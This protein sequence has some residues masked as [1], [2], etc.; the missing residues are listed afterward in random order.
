M[1]LIYTYAG[2]LTF[3][4]YNDGIQFFLI[5]P[6]FL[7]LELVNLK[8]SGGRSGLMTQLDLCS[9]AKGMPVAW[10]NSRVPMGCSR[11]EL[12]IRQNI[13]ST[14]RLRAPDRAL[15]PSRET[16][17]RSVPTAALP[18]HI[19][20]SPIVKTGL[21]LLVLATAPHLSAQSPGTGDADH[22]KL[23]FQQSCAL[24]HA[25]VLG[26]GGQLVSGQ[27]PS[28]VGVV[29]RPAASLPNFNYS[30]ALL[31]SGLVWTAPELD[32]FLEAPGA[33]VPG[34]TMPVGVPKAQDRLD[35]IAFLSTVAAP[36]TSAG[37]PSAAAAPASGEDL[38]DW[39]HDAPGNLHRTDLSALPAPFS[40]P[41][42]GNG[43]KVVERPNYAALAVPP[44][45]KVRLFA[46]D[47]SGPRL[48]RV[49]PN[50]DIFIA[51][52]RA[53]RIHILRAAD[54]ASAPLVDQ[55]FAEGLD[56]PFGIAFYPLGGD[57]QWVYVANNNSVVRFPYRSG[58]LTARGDPETILPM[59]A[60]ESSGGH[61][62]RDV[63]FSSDG[64]RMFVSVGSGSNV[65]EGLVTKSA[66]ERQSWESGHGFGAAWGAE[67]NRANVLVSDPEGHVPLHT[68]ATGIRNAVGLAVHPLTGS[69][70]VAVN[71]R[72]GLGDNLVPD[73][74]SSVKE[75][76]FYGWPW[77]Y[78]GDH[79]DPRH[80]GE[81]PD[82][83]GHVLVPDVPVQSHSAALE[84]TFYT[85]TSGVSLFPAEYRNDIFAA[86]H[87]SWNRS[88][89]TG[90]KVV[91]VR[92]KDGVPTGDYED[93]LTGFVVDGSN[94]WGRPVG[95]AVAHDGALLVTEDG[96]DTL[97]RISYNGG[98]SGKP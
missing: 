80:A 54:G 69:L 9:A 90:Y 57:P 5:V 64:L 97:W 81:R 25:T 49:A 96:N 37:P 8:D 98:P 15:E 4:I 63:A 22:G 26:P 42:S 19:T 43:P 20:T 11:G 53:G 70:W 82:L 55:V 39:H 21:I 52:T 12:M 7:V 79:E 32:H 1:V 51:E 77:Y 62:T 35:L 28:L 66:E 60:P 33:A 50:G 16:F 75:K 24:C 92:F 46:G 61:T 6:G 34:T 94:V 74:L 56:R 88:N 31:A 40:T 68:Y 3:A 87:G 41:S 65:A 45:F 76:G 73:Y 71:E 48:M 29:G 47:L 17:K 89:R 27:G 78:M 91:R 95:V 67:T 58:D 44:G 86:F 72:D 30:K 84:F 85:A 14:C 38:G 18:M 59:L 83:P 36:T 10:T 2:G 13:L 93:F 23:L